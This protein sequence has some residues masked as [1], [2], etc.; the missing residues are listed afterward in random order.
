MIVVALLTILL[1]VVYTLFLSTIRTANVQDSQ[2]RLRDESR[3]A[4]RQ[5]IRVVRMA[6]STTLRGILPDGSVEPM[7]NGV[8]YNGIIVN[9]AT[10]LDG[11]FSSL[12]KNSSLSEFAS[13]IVFKLG[14]LPDDGVYTSTQLVAL[15]GDGTD[16][17]ST[18]PSGTLLQQFSNRVVAPNNDAGGRN[19]PNGGFTLSKLGD[20]VT[21]RLVMEQP[22]QAMNTPVVTTE[23]RQVTIRN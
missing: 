3:E 7:A 5:M 18:D 10:D 15:A 20:V 12:Q 14:G 11:N 21:F 1:G 19:A 2:I 4:M 9:P 16:G 8:L 22:G 6:N 23:E 13:D 17:T